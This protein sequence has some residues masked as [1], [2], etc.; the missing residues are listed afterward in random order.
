MLSRT[1]SL[2][3]IKS[4]VE[5]GNADQVLAA[6]KTMPAIRIESWYQ[7]LWKM[8]NEVAL[9]DG[10]FRE[11]VSQLDGKQ[12]ESATEEQLLGFAAAWDTPVH[13]LNLLLLLR[14]T[15]VRIRRL[16]LESLSGK[17]NAEIGASKLDMALRHAL[18]N[19]GDNDHRKVIEKLLSLVNSSR[20]RC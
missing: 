15:D 10:K 19:E 18:I 2:V 5:S 9:A 6:I 3:I 8:R 16:V 17:S 20:P 12:L 7:D 13:V 11:M 1:E 14:A 4:I